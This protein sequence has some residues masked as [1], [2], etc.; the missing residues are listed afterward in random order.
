MHKKLR[1]THES[2]N[3]F[4]FILIGITMFAALGYSISKGFRSDTSST[5]TK[6][7]IDLAADDILTYAQKIGRTV[8]RLRRNGC[9]ESEI[10]FENP[11]VSGY[12]FVT[13]DKCKVFD[14]A[15]GGITYRPPS[16]DWLDADYAGN[17]AY[18]ELFFG[19][20]QIIFNIGSNTAE[21]GNDLTI[22]IPFLSASICTAINKK[23]DID[24]IPDANTGS[25][26]FYDGGKF[27]GVF[28]NGGYTIAAQ[29]VTATRAACLN[30]KQN[31]G[32]TTDAHNIFYSVI[33]ER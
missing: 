16:L 15:G 14:T 17:F 25:N 23:L 4:L 3:V 6:K 7:Q 32:T 28:Q 27:I 20:N 1:R 21:S 9:S 13:R 8:D 19:R 10:S 30:A 33:L 2:G 22:F 24:D 12:D 31:F 18:G 29:G 26:V 5:L 11:V